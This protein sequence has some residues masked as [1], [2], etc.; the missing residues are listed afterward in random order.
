MVVSVLLCAPGCAVCYQNSWGCVVPTSCLC[1][2]HFQPYQSKKALIIERLG[3][4]ALL[5][6]LA[7]S[8]FPACK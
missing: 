1:S 5:C 3:V 8:L 2:E 4:T 7:N 6:R